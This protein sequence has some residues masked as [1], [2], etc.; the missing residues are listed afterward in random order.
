MDILVS[1]A[2]GA[3]GG[4]L[5][6]SQDVG[7]NEGGFFFGGIPPVN[8]P[9]LLVLLGEHPQIIC[10]FSMRGSQKSWTFFTHEFSEYFVDGDEFGGPF[11]ARIVSHSMPQLSKLVRAFEHLQGFRCV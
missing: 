7:L 6:F 4:H 1:S 8:L 2:T 10:S 5:D 9:L 3:C 11:G